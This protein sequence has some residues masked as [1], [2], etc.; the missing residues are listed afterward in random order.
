MYTKDA[1]EDNVLHSYAESNTGNIEVNTFS[2]FT[3]PQSNQPM[4]WLTKPI[5]IFENNNY[6]I[7]NLYPFELVKQI[8]YLIAHAIKNTCNNNS[9]A[10]CISSYLRF[11][12]IFSFNKES[13]KALYLYDNGLYIKI[14]KGYKIK[15]VTN[16]NFKCKLLEFMSGVIT[17]YEI[18]FYE[19][20]KIINYK[21]IG[22]INFKNEIK[23]RKSSSI[24]MFSACIT[25][26]DHLYFLRYKSIQKIKIQ[27]QLKIYIWIIGV[28]LFSYVIIS[29]YKYMVYTSHGQRFVQKRLQKRYVQR[30]LATFV[31]TKFI[32]L[33]VK[34]VFVSNFIVW[35]L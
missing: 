12:L 22:N 8:H 24:C 32:I 19:N 11:H 6:I 33:V 7:S 3:W 21:I 29:V 14:N 27:N 25:L 31:L 34:A 13:F 4:T 10:G 16:S 9:I 26:K 1:N 28:L 23:M 35:H 30:W 17:F 5:P 18:V 2:V 20:K 15:T